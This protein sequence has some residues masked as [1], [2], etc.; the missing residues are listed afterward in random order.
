MHSWAKEVNIAVF[1]NC[2]GLD[3]QLCLVGRGEEFKGFVYY[4]SCQIVIRG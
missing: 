1:C 4:A 2:V 3:L